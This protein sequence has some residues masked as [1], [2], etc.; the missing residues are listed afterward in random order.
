M[1]KNLLFYRLNLFDLLFCEGLGVFHLL[2]APVVENVQLLN[3]KRNSI[4]LFLH[5]VLGSLAC[6]QIVV[7]VVFCRQHVFFIFRDSLSHF[8]PIRFLFGQS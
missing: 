4:Q 7:T 6:N 2:F 8:G 3:L 1:F 5:E